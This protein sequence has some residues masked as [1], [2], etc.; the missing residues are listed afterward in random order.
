MSGFLRPDSGPVRFDGHD[1]TGRAPHLNARAG[2][3][4]TFQIVQPFA[5]QTVRE[6]I[7]VGAHLHE[8]R[9]RRRAGRR[10]SRG[11]SAWAWRRSSTSPPPT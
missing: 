8:P 11:A 4:R 2:M 5:A 6:N 7:A 1:I 3:T 10:R 9:P